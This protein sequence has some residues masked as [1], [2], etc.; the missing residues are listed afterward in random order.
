MASLKITTNLKLI[1]GTTLSS[2]ALP[3]VPAAKLPAMTN[4]A[5]GIA[6]AGN[7]LA[8]ISGVVSVQADTGIKV[9][10]DGVHAD[11]V[12]AIATI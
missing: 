8:A 12:L 5:K 11:V 4:S 6:Q 2:D 1:D 9:G 7:G 10:A 3:T